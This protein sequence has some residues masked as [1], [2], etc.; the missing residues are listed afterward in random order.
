MITRKSYRL[1]QTRCCESMLSQESPKKKDVKSIPSVVM[2]STSIN[3]SRCETPH[4]GRPAPHR[5]PLTYLSTGFCP[6]ATWLRRKKLS[7][8]TL[9]TRIEKNRTDKVGIALQS[10]IRMHARIL[11]LLPDLVANDVNLLARVLE[12]AREER[13]GEGLEALHDLQV[14]PGADFFLR[15]KKK[16]EKTESACK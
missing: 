9:E 13:V 15:K 8:L 14:V 3:C 11:H 16:K 1:S 5:T 4:D 12:H 7:T 10:E 6:Y 2:S